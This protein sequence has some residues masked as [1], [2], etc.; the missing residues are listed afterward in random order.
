LLVLK[1]FLSGCW[2]AVLLLC[3]WGL[4]ETAAPASGL[5]FGPDV[6][7]ML[8]CL[9]VSLG[10]FFWLVSEDDADTDAEADAESFDD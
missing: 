5:R 3:F 8:G 2:L 9:V 7:L 10:M 1:T 4:L 6:L